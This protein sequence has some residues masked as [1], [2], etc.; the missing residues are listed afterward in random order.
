[1]KRLVPA[2]LRRAA[3]SALA[4]APATRVAAPAKIGLP[5]SSRLAAGFAF[6]PVMTMLLTA[7][8]SA[9]TPE[10]PVALGTAASFAVL[11]ASTVTNTGDTVIIGDLGLSPGTSVTGF[12]PGTVVGGSIH[13]ADTGGSR[14]HVIYALGNDATADSAMVASIR[15]ELDLAGQWFATETGATL[16]IDRT[17]GQ[18]D[19]TT[20][21]LVNFTNAQL[22]QWEAQPNYGP[23][24]QL[25]EDGFGFPDGGRYLVYID[26]TSTNGYCGLAYNA[27]ATVYQNGGCGSV[28]APVGSAADVGATVNTAQVALHEMLH[29]LGVVPTCAPNFDNYHAKDALHDLMW[30][31]I[32]TDKHVD[33]G[34]DDYFHHDHAGCVDIEDSPFLSTNPG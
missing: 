8:S 29:A 31:V 2:I 34:H 1:M 13:V 32:G 7:Q 14:F 17:G 4:P 3:D 22:L 23:L 9:C 5:G 19:V 10:E 15:T 33:V 24:T 28:L 26:G 16:D 18:I 21:Q 30:P 25:A 20:W 6:I 12:P 11:G 27:Y